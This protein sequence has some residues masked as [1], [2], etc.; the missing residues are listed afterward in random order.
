MKDHKCL[1]SDASRNLKVDMEGPVDSGT[2]PYIFSASR[3][4]SVA[5]GKVRDSQRDSKMI[6]GFMLGWSDFCDL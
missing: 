3:S 1:D 2:V 5:T 4:G 6:H